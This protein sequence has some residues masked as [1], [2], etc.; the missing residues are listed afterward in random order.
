MGGHNLVLIIFSVF[1]LSSSAYASRVAQ[2]LAPGDFD[3]T[4]PKYGGKPNTD[5]SQVNYTYY[6]RTNTSK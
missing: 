1:L 2:F 6:N 4:S 3:V 5:I